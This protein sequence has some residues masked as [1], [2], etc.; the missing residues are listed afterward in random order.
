MNATSR[1]SQ[2]LIPSK[3]NQSFPIAK[4]SFR[5]TPKHRQSAKLNSRKNLVPHGRGFKRYSGLELNKSKTEA[6]WL[7]KKNTP[8]PANLFYIYWP[9]KCRCLDVCLKRF[10]AP[11]T[12]S[13]K[14]IPLSILQP[15]SGPLLFKC[16]FVLKALPDFPLLQQFYKDILSAWEEVVIHTPTTRNNALF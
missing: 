13:W 3:E 5:K 10:L 11:E 7:E 8:Q 16:N 2:K 1:K 6:M 12:Q 14:T 4:V 9:H 15:V